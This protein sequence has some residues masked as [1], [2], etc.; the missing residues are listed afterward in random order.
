MNQRNYL[1]SFTKSLML[2]CTLL[3]Q[4]VAAQTPKPLT[5][6]ELVQL[7]Y[8]LPKH[9]EKRDEVV[10]EI[11]K[12]GLGFELTS[13]LRGVVATKSGNDTLIL[14][15][16]EE[17]ERRRLNPTAAALPT[18]AEAQDVLERARQTQLAVAKGMPDFVVKQLVARSYALGQT[19]NWIPIDHLTV[20]VSYRESAGGEQYKLLAVNG[21]PQTTDTQEH[22]SYEQESG[23]S[24]TGE[25]VSILT[26][27]FSGEA[28]ADFKA[29]DT[30][31]VRGRRTI[32]Y[33][34]E[35]KKVNS[36]HTLKYSDHLGGSE[37]TVVGSRG[38]VWIDRETYRVLRLENIA[39]EIPAGFPI[40]AANN[41][42]DYDYV[43]ISGHQYL[44]PIHAAVELTTIQNRQTYQ[45]L[46]DIRFRNYQKFGTEVKILEDDDVTDEAPPK[47]KP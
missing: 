8:Q 17:A 35:V 9:P 21:L 20:A 43:T 18:A 38:R 27:L 11:R 15:T 40:T 1:F 3:V 33:E 47:K 10:E 34:Y 19:K 14:R 36:S 2:L 39:T 29:A 26:T 45:T 13:G 42:V 24:S 22:G 6:Q 37:Q 31:T 32:I 4:F 46:N 12:R 28:H 25:F 44:L 23:A 7:V 41:L 16:L 5:Q 30:D